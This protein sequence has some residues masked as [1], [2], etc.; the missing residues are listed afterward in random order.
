MSAAER[1]AVVDALVTAL[2]DTDTEVR[3][4]VVTMKSPARVLARFKAEQSFSM[5]DTVRS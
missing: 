3:R 4:D 1:E 2:K 5:S